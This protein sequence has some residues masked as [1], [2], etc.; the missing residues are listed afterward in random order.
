MKS[1]GEA[2]SVVQ[3][4]E[5]KGSNLAEGSEVCRACQIPGQKVSVGFS[6]YST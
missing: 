6:L 5:G 4:E 3:A 2:D 1:S